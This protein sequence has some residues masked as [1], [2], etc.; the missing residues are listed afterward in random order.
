ME[1]PTALAFVTLLV[2]GV[3]LTGCQTTPKPGTELPRDGD[4]I[5]V[6]GRLFNIGTPVVLW[7]DPGG[8][9]AYRVEARFKPFEQ[10]DWDTIKQDMPD[11]AQP[12]RY[13]LRIDRFHNGTPDFTPEQIEQVRG[14]GWE[15]EQLQGIVDQFVIHYDVCG[16]SQFCFEVLHDMRCLSVHFMLDVDGTIYQTADL[17]ERAWHAGKANSRSVGIEIANIGAYPPDDDD[18]LQQWYPRGDDGLRYI[19]IPERR[20]SDRLAGKRFRPRADEP[21][22]GHI[23]GRELKQY[24]LTEAQYRALGNLTAAL[25]RIFPKL[26]LA[27][28]RDAEGNVRMDVLS[29][30]EFAQY[31]G[32]IGHYHLTTGKIDPGPAFDWERVIAD[33]QAH[34]K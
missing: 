32:L 3:L 24:D 15:L 25:T 16:T 12:N 28:P 17:K 1:H 27:V 22:V 10:S 23:H 4:E 11:W 9:D 18:T 20:L 7:T 30:E 33:A 34:L 8:Y 31:H 2:L 29:D 5:M 26:P 14:G 13:G 19:D 6:A 21:I